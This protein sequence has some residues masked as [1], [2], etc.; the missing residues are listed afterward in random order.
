VALGKASV[1]ISVTPRALG[2]I[3]IDETKGL[4]KISMNS[5][6]KPSPKL[7]EDLHDSNLQ[8]AAIIFQNQIV[9]SLHE[10]VRQLAS[11]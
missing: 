8:L 9:A 7:V 2:S 1:S 11:C 10:G 5:L 3:Q 4:L 6:A